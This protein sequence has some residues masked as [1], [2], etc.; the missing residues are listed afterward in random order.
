[1]PVDDTDS[2]DPQSQIDCLPFLRK[3]FLILV[4]KG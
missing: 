2:D 3:K 4:V 1:M